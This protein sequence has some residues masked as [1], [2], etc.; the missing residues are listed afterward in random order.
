MNGKNPELTVEA[1]VATKKNA[2]KGR[3]P[4]SPVWKVLDDARKKFNA[5]IVKST[6][7]KRECIKACIGK[8]YADDLRFW[9]DL[10]SQSE[11]LLLDSMRFNKACDNLGLAPKTVAQHILFES[12]K[13]AKRIL[14]EGVEAVP[15][16]RSPLTDY[17]AERGISYDIASR[18]CCRL[19]YGVRG[20]RY[21]AV[22][23][24]NVAG[25]YEIR[26]R[27]FKGCVPP[28][29]VSLVKA[30]GSPADVCSVFEGFMDFLSAVTLGLE[31]GDCLVLNSISNVEKAMRYLDGYGRI[32]CYLDRDEAGRRTLEMLKGHY[33]E[34]VCDR[35]ALYDGCKDLNE[36]LQ[37]T[38]KKEMNNNL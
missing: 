29:D 38:T 23:F 34:R 33:G 6:S 2:G 16:L 14:I 35:S 18:Y 24:P 4:K 7:V 26:S 13:T 20:K 30:E 3:T 25:G 21:F 27:F 8:Y 15:L 19:N 17:L 1:K 12:E 11:K 31:T 37:L 36:Y 22:G 10:L 28:K 5:Q 32:D 9:L